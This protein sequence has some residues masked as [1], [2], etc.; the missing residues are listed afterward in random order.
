[1]AHLDKALVARYFF[2]NDY[3]GEIQDYGDTVKINQIGDPSIFK[4]VRNQD[5]PM[6]EELSMV[7]QE[8]IIDQAD[9]FN[10]QVDDI[11]AQQARGNLID[12]GMSR[13]AYKLAS[14]ENTFLF[15]RLAEAVPTQNTIGT[16]GAP[17]VVT[18]DNVY[19]LVV[20]LRTILTKANVPMGARQ[21]AVPPE[22]VAM[23]LQDDRFTGTGGTFAEG[24]LLSGMIARGAGFGFYEVNNLPETGGV[25]EVIANDPLSSTYAAQIVKTEAYRM[26][27]RFAD[28]LKGLNVYGAK[29]LVPQAV[30][31]AYV[32]FA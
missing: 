22:M 5:M 30:A 14:T 20:Q 32:T 28:G 4:Y 25:Y 26:E 7:D 3:E 6:P 8:L 1:M 9:A 11:D 15:G 21:I 2:N 10:F 27:R 23:I 16:P 18:E 12:P 24:T 13:A 17:I 31:K 19:S 29:V